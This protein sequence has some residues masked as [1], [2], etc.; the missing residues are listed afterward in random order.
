MSEHQPQSAQAAVTLSSFSATRTGTSSVSSGRTIR[1]NSTASRRTISNIEKMSVFRDEGEAPRRPEIAGNNSTVSVT[2]APT[3]HVR[4][5]HSRSISDSTVSQATPN[6]ALRRDRGEE[7]CILNGNGEEYEDAATSASDLIQ[8]LQ[9]IGAKRTQLL[10]ELITL[11]SEET[12]TLAQLANLTYV[13]MRKASSKPHYNATVQAL[14]P[15]STFPTRTRMLP[16]TQDSKATQKTIK[17]KPMHTRPV[18]APPESTPAGMRHR[19]PLTS[20][21]HPLADET[22]E[23]GAVCDIPLSVKDFSTSTANMTDGQIVAAKESMAVPSPSRL[24]RTMRIPINFGDSSTIGGDQG[25]SIES[26]NA[27]SMMR[28]NCD[29][30]G[31]SRGRSK[32]RDTSF[33]RGRD[34][35]SR[36]RSKSRSRL[37]GMAATTPG[38]ARLYEIPHT[39]A[40][41]RWEF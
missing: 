36:S 34:D 16:S 18:S 4:S 5:R 17:K 24:G 30:V 27:D 2:T 41:K 37:T 23:L 39:V 28:G 38:I 15:T 8:K 21:R 22:E 40:R 26:A 10:N 12:A 3:G 29:G 32:D 7:P 25:T 13:S 9:D 6:A 31:V 14:N 20:K 1:S 19:T 11:E 35:K 33:T